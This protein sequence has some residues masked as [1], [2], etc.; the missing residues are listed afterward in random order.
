MLPA[1]LRYWLFDTL[2]VQTMRYVSA[3][4]TREAKGLTKAVYDQIREDFFKNGSLTSRSRVPEL[5]AA[6]WTGGRE[7]MLVA[8]KVDRTTKDAITALLSRI[9]DCP[10][11][12]DMLIS[13][14]HAAGDHDA[15]NDLFV[16]DEFDASDDLLRR[17]LA[18]VRAIATAGATDCVDEITDTPFTAEQLP[19]II[20]T[21]MGMSDINRFSHVVM[22][23]SPV[24]AP[25]GLRTVKAWALR[26][27]GRELEVT[28]R[29]P[30]VPGRALGLLPPAE[31]PEDMQ[32]AKPNP[33]VADAVA[34]W[35]A[36]VEREGAKV[37][38][39]R[40]REVV[41]RELR[42]WRGEQMPLDGA[43]IEAAIEGLD[44]EE[45]A[46][47]R[48]AIVVAKASYRTTDN[49]VDDVMGEA[50]DQA[51]FIRI[52]AWSSFTAA[53]HFARIVAERSGAN[54]PAVAKLQPANAA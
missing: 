31:L 49:M 54:A 12:E 45:R 7:S 53:R 13:L 18:W 47:A 17:R 37:I 4:P 35:T 8:D 28:R 25:F 1:K 43:W 9:N 3:V 29:V 36:A 39:Q 33:R 30:L 15:A 34:R 14:V 50:R 32:W 41:G 52:L 40:V 46:I 26:M 10:Y 6:V 24:P 16:G 38:S 44:G 19:E 23:D 2:S 22:E 11:C 42:D 21:L 5:M 27:F 20:G 51:R 48:L